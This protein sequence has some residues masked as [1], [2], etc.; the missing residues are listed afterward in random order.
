MRSVTILLI[1]AGL[2]AACGGELTAPTPQGTRASDVPAGADTPFL[3][4]APFAR[5]LTRLPANLALTSAQKQAIQGFVASFQTTT[6]ADRQALRSAFEQARQARRS[7]ATGDR[8]RP[9]FQ[10]TAPARERMRTATAQLRQQIEGALTADQKAWLAANVCDPAGPRLTDAQ[11]AQVRSLLTAFRQANQ[12][13]LTTVRQAFEQARQARQG[14]ATADR[15]QAILAGA[16]P[17]R[18]RLAAAH[19]KLAADVKALLT[20]A[21]RTSACFAPG[22]RRGPGGFRAGFR[23]GAPGAGGGGFGPGFAPGFR[24][25]AAVH[26]S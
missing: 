20:P 23:R 4:H 16:Q 3:A 19:Q 6:Q 26:S 15:L 24:R 22:L 17:A 7:G 5:W 18:A 25:G 9:L 12:A 10:Q 1:A 11:K 8:L 13:D 2:L 21:Q 14:G